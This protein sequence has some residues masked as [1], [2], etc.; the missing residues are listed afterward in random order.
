MR[1]RALSTAAVGAFLLVVAS[2][3]VATVGIAEARISGPGLGEG[4]LNITPPA[5]E[6][7]WDAGL[8]WADGLDDTRVDSIVAL[9]LTAA[10]LV[11]HTS[12]PWP[13]HGS[14]CDARAGLPALPSVRGS[15]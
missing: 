2:P 9:G 5:T 10:E 11:P 1:A 15:H 7:L 14:I 13:R 4:G 8:D 6:G 12:S 3:A